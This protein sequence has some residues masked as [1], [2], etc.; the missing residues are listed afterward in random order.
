MWMM[1]K[2]SS[3]RLSFTILITIVQ[4]CVPG[5]IK[6]RKPSSERHPI[7]Q[8][9]RQ[10]PCRPA[11]PWHLVQGTRGERGRG[12]ASYPKAWRSWKTG[13]V[14]G[15]VFGVWL[16]GAIT[17][18]AFEQVWDSAGPADT[19]INININNGV[20]SW[21]RWLR[22]VGVRFEQADRSSCVRIYI[23]L[24]M[25]RGKEIS[26]ESFIPRARHHCLQWTGEYNCFLV[27]S[28]QRPCR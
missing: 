2:R 4:P 1:K 25:D 16:S 22:F 17:A 14:W 27:N 5:N 13:I 26:E 21:S 18:M 24:Q 11:A 8:H 23:S 15:L 28:C 12:I 9:Q 19:G 7:H 3:L 6:F 20:R 10:L